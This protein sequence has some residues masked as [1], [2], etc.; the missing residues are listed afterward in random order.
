[1]GGGRGG[2]AGNPVLIGAATVLVVLVAVFLAYNANHGLPFVPSYRLTAELPNASGLIRGNEVRIGGAR[3]G[4]VSAIDAVARPDGS[5]GAR[6][7]LQPEAAQPEL[8]RDSRILVRSRSPLGLKYVEIT[9]GHARERLPDGAAMPRSAAAVRP[10]ELDEVFGMFDTPTRAGV[11][12]GV[13]SRRS[14]P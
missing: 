2:I 12:G 7:H 11:A 14:R 9:R 3:V 5:T 13:A 1:M 6:L 8:P 4:V 10:V